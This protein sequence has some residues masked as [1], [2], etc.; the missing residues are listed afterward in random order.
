MCNVW[1]GLRCLEDWKINVFL[2]IG[3]ANVNV[4]AR[5]LEKYEIE[6]AERW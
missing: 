6:V 5:E 2:R 4:L 1:N 3:L